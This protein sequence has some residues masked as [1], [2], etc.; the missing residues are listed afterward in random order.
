VFAQ[1]YA[2]RLILLDIFYLFFLGGFLAF[3]STTLTVMVRWPMA[4]SNIPVWIWFLLPV[5]Y[6]FADFAEDSLIFILLR[7]LAT[8]QDK[9][10]NVLGVLT[11]IK[12][13]AIT[14]SILQVLLLCLASYIPR[15]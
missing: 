15:N 8:I 11:A 3:A 5:V 10:M 14:L 9:S 2:T 12:I 1:G 7:W 13:K 6:I 4:L